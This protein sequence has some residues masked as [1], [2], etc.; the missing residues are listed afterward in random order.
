[1]LLLF[2]YIYMYIYIYLCLHYLACKSNIVS[3]IVCTIMWFV[4]VCR[5][6]RNYLFT[7]TVVG[8]QGQTYVT[9]NDCFYCNYNFFI[10]RLSF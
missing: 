5:T 10:E 4:R 7:G 2:I 3:A 6:F 1:M 8:K 9:L